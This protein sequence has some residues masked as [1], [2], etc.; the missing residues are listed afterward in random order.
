[1]LL[2]NNGVKE[3]I[4]GELKRYIEANKNDN[5]TYQN[6]WDAGKAVIKKCLFSN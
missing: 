1:M 6:F 2:K 5:T 3:E 4:K